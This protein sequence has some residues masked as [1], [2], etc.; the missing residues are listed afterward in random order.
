MVFLKSN[1]HSYDPAYQPTQ[2]VFQPRLGLF[3]YM[4]S[5][6]ILKPTSRL[7]SGSSRIDDSAANIASRVI[8]RGFGCSRVVSFP[9][10]VNWLASASTIFFASMRSLLRVSPR[11]LSTRT[12]APILVTDRLRFVLCAAH[13]FLKIVTTRKRWFVLFTIPITPSIAN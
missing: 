13:S 1:R 10:Y 5:Y 6:G 3:P 9:Y 4:P 12:T 8:V 11:L 7:V 2:K